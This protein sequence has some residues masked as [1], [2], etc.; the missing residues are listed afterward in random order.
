MA[1][2]RLDPVVID[3][4]RIPDLETSRLSAGQVQAM[5]RLAGR[6]FLHTWM[7]ADALAEESAEWRLLE[8]TTG[9]KARNKELQRNLGFA[10]RT[11]RVGE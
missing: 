10:F 1:Y 11:F 5:R 9:N 2:A 7:L 6:T 8:N 3:A 4:A